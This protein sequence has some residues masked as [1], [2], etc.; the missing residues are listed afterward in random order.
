[1]LCRCTCAAHMVCRW[2]PCDVG[3]DD[4]CAAL[5]AAV[6]I[7]MGGAGAAKARLRDLLLPHAPSS[8]YRSGCPPPM[9]VCPQCWGSPGRLTSSDSTWAAQRWPPAAG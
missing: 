2:L 4:E 3:C 7:A 5:T 9:S 8:A 6:S 1:M